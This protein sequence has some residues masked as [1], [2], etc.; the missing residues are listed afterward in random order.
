MASFN[1][2]KLTDTLQRA[3][4]KFTYYTDAV[5]SPQVLNTGGLTS[6]I[7]WTDLSYGLS[8]STASTSLVDISKIYWSISNAPNGAATSYTPS[9]A[10]SWGIPSAAM[11]AGNVAVYL[12]GNGQWDFNEHGIKLA[13]PLTGAQRI[14]QIDIYNA[15]S[16]TGTDST[17]FSIF[18]EV[19][20]VS[21]FGITG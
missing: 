3:V 12:S 18:I 11:T 15:T 20:K 14:N 21:G 19:D 1:K 13:N 8:G 7:L 9:V 4:Y 5:V 10:V 6:S 17:A 2:Q 16:I